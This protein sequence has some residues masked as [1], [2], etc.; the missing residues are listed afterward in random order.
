MKT[1]GLK[2]ATE[3]ITIF[4][5]KF[6]KAVAAAIYSEAQAVLTEAKI[7]VPYITGNL[8]TTGDVLPVRKEGGVA[9]VAE[10]VFTAPYALRVHEEPRPPSSNGTFKYLEIP[11]KE[12]S[13]GYANRVA[14]KAS[15]LMGG[16]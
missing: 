8:Q 10:V 12:A 11:L 14:A 13:S 3:A 9:L 15:R 2:K 16:S 5:T 1:Q 7:L 4:G 6:E